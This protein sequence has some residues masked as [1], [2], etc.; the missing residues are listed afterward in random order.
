MNTVKT[1][2]NNFFG[3]FGYQ[4]NKAPY[5]K[6][7]IKSGHYRWLQNFGIKTILDIGANE[8]QF[9]DKISK[10]LPEANIFSFEPLQDSFKKLE[11]K[12]SGKKNITIFN[13]ALGDQ[14][15]ETIINRNEYSPSSSL[16][17]LT[18]LHKNAFPITKEAKEEKIYVKELDKIANELE[19]KKKV[20]MKIDVQG[21]ELN[22]LRGAENTI[23]EV[24]IILIETSFY[25]LYKNQPLFGDIFNFLSDGGFNYYGS[26][27]QLYDVRDGR[28][29]QADSIFISNSIL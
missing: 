5:S 16:L 22:V 11:E 17:E 7:M 24:D 15:K 12:V 1:Y 25:E 28:I 27:E 4:L 13:F 14:E 26:L 19:L 23:K 2:L 20:M 9:I 6:R 3:L 8:G 10:I 29:L 18:D 21:Y